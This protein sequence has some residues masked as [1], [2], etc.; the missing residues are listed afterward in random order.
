MRCYQVPSDELTWFLMHEPA[1]LLVA[2]FHE[3]YQFKPFMMQLVGADIARKA[4]TQRRGAE[5]VEE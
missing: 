2:R 5:Q 1:L 3:M 4:G